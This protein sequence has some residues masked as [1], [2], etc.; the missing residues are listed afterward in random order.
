MAVLD[1]DRLKA[2]AVPVSRD[3]Y[4]P[5]DT[6]LYA[7]GTGAGLSDQIDELGLV[8]ERRLQAL[9][10]MALVL[11]TPGFWLMDPKLELDWAKILH[12]EQ[13]LRL[14]RPLD[15]HG[16]LTG[17]TRI[18][19]L[20]DKGAG[21]P[22][23]LRCHR[24]LET[25]GGS[26]VAEMDETWVLR[27]AGGFGGPRTL[28]GSDPVV[29]PDVAPDATIDLPTSPQQA[30]LYRLSGDRNPLH[31]EPQ[32]ARIG[33]FDRP[34]LHG[35]ATM[36]LAAR[37]LI[38]LCCGGDPARLSS[39]AVRFTAPVYPGDTI[40]TEIWRD[41]SNI[42]FRAAVTGRGQVVM[43]GGRASIDAFGEDALGR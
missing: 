18:G 37:A 1:V 15:P 29:L 19:D 35:L 22:A 25:L 16:E 7:L 23:L 6:I 34:I 30:M 27:E 10:T 42:L 8:F 17:S 13:S 4:D 40:R 38:H 43:D 28:P 33:G 39:I 20:A 31:I 12:G 32:T 41:G 24:R 21:K 26:L 3:A 2:Y 14:H 36:G 5:R 9:P 11:G